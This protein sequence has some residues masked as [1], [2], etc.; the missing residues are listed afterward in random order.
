MSFPEF[1][2]R[3]SRREWGRR[4]DIRKTEGDNEVNLNVLRLAGVRKV[5]FLVGNYM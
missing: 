4:V 2:I 5:R 3:S 1:R